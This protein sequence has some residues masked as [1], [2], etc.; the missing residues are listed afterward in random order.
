MKMKNSLE[1]LKVQSW[2]TQLILVQTITAV[3]N[4]ENRLHFKKFEMLK[5]QAT[6]S[7]TILLMNIQSEL[8]KTGLF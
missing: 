8:I 4:H 7:L 1:M 3:A 5:K 2:Y 6:L